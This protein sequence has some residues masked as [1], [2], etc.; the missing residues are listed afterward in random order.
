[1]S[2]VE[3]I[4]TAGYLAE[5]HIVKTED[6]YILTLQRIVPKRASSLSREPVAMNVSWNM[7]GSVLSTSSITPSSQASVQWQS[8]ASPNRL[9]SAPMSPSYGKDTCPRLSPTRSL[10]N[11]VNHRTPIL[12]VHGFMQDSECWVSHPEN[13]KNLAFLLVDDGYD[14]WLGNNRGTRYCQKHILYKASENRF[15]DYSLDE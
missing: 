8:G 15:W 5:E 4:E 11:A 13:L 6:G 10:P 7:D 12:L 1:M 14:V 2:T 3:L 9:K